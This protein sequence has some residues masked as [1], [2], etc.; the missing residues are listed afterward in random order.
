MGTDRKQ[1]KEKEDGLAKCSEKIKTKGKKGSQENGLN[2]Y[3][4]ILKDLIEDVKS[5]IYSTEY[6]C[7]ATGT[8]KATSVLEKHKKLATKEWFPLAGT[9]QDIQVLP[10]GSRTLRLSS[11]SLLAVQCLPMGVAMLSGKLV[12]FQTNDYP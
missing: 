7:E 1:N 2:E 12:C 5:K 4:D 10:S 6:I 8:Y 11:I 9:K 3:V